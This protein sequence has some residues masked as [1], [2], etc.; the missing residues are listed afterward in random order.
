[1]FSVSASVRTVL[2]TYLVPSMD[3]FPHGEATMNSHLKKDG[4]C[5]MVWFWDLFWVLV[6]VV[7]WWRAWGFSG[8]GI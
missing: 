4:A 3:G 7:V 1:M 2:C 8:F 6:V 5:G